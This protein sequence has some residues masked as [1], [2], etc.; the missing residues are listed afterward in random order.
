MT[1]RRP[2]GTVRRRNR[3][4]HRGDYQPDRRKMARAVATKSPFANPAPPIEQQARIY[5]MARCNLGHPRT[6][7]LRFSDNPQHL[8]DAP[9]V[10]ALLASDDLNRSITI[11]AETEIS[12]APVF[13]ILFPRHSAERPQWALTVTRYTAA[14][15][16]TA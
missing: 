9:A 2:G 7:L 8:L 4:L 16:R 5:P 13:L 3:F 1:R 10:P 12:F 11:M 6:R 15:S 14:R